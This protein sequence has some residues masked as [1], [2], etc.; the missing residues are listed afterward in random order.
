MELKE[1]K[2]KTVSDLQRL[3]HEERDKLIQLRF[4]DGGR[5]LKNVRELRFIKKDIARIITLLN[6]KSVAKKDGKVETP[7]EGKK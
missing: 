5:Q 6:E 2:T 4:K 7:V 3:L 1:M